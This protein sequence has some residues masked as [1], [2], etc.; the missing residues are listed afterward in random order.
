MIEIRDSYSTV[1]EYIQYCMS[2]CRKR[3]DGISVGFQARGPEGT[4]P[5]VAEKKKIISAVF[6]YC[7]GLK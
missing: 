1:T 3:Y 7:T 6:D 4:K 5:R 2:L